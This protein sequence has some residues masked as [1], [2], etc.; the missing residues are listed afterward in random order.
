M[1]SP[2]ESPNNAPSAAGDFRMDGADPASETPCIFH[3]F[4]HLPQELRDLIWDAAARNAYEPYHTAT[5]ENP[6]LFCLD[7]RSVHGFQPIRIDARLSFKAAEETLI[8]GLLPLLLTNRESSQQIRRAIVGSLAKDERLP[9][10]ALWG[11]S[12]R[13][14]PIRQ[15]VMARNDILCLHPCC[16]WITERHVMYSKYTALIIYQRLRHI[17]LWIVQ[18]SAL[19]PERIGTLLQRIPHLETLY[20]DANS[21]GLRRFPRLAS[22]GHAPCMSHGLEFKGHFTWLCDLPL[23]PPLIHGEENID[24]Q[25]EVT[26]GEVDD[27]VDSSEATDRS[28]RVVNYRR[29]LGLLYPDRFQSFLAVWALCAAA[30]VRLRFVA[31]SGRQ[32]ERYYHA[33]FLVEAV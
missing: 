25:S 17:M 29:I 32:A 33:K 3:R 2:L 5:E 4:Q 19:G 20:V 9:F 13:D 10:L 24:T 12:C 18:I 30:G 14:V 16:V 31:P 1:E 23:H 11:Y 21:M 6:R 26:S 28:E 27:G 22:G 7:G 15:L 8:K